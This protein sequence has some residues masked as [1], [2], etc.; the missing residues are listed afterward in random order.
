MLVVF[1]YSQTLVEFV[2]ESSGT[3][4]VSVNTALAPGGRPETLNVTGLPSRLVRVS[5]LVI[6]VESPLPTGTVTRSS[7]ALMW[8]DWAE[9]E[10]ARPRAASQAAPF[11][12]R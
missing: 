8:M 5:Q 11:R 12:A 3:E 9:A 6:S 1:R 4:L 10:T 7:E 2:M